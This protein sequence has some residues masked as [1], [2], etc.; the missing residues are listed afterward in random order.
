MHATAPL[1]QLSIDTVDAIA[2]VH[3]WGRAFNDRDLDSLLELSHPNIRLGTEQREE[4]G[5]DAVRRMLHL[6]SYGVA[7]HVRPL[8]FVAQGA[9]VAVE[10]VL[11]LRW[12]D[13]GELAG[14]EEGVALFEI[15]DGRVQSFCPQPDLPSAFRHAGW[16]PATTLQTEERS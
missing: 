4:H 15:R 7:Q 13:G 11:E 5:H 6:Q 2:V 8:R 10:S 9:T 16:P 14:T 3:A 1:V 12:V